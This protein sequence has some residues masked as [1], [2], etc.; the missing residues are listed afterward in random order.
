MPQTPNH[1]NVPTLTNLVAPGNP[2]KKAPAKILSSKTS[3]LDDLNNRIDEI[4]SAIGQ[5]NSGP[6]GRAFAIRSESNKKRLNRSPNPSETKV[7][8]EIQ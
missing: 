3:H 4:E 8:K 2:R 6:L 5:D 1:N 7:D